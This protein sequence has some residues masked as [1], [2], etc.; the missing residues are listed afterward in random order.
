MLDFLQ[1][2]FSLDRSV[3]IVTGLLLLI[4][5]VF[6]QLAFPYRP[7]IYFIHNEYQNESFPADYRESNVKTAICL[8]VLP[9]NETAAYSLL[10][11][12]RLYGQETF[13]FLQSI[14]SQ[15]YTVFLY[16]LFVTRV[17]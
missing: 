6:R 11:H 2:S 4:I 7:S 12:I 17:T 13:P 5:T 8:H 1:S 9:I 16:A 14:L 10:F 3:G 15:T